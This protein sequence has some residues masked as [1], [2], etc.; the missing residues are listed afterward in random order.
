MNN[1]SGKIFVVTGP[2]G[3]GKD[4]VLKTAKQM[5]L[6][7]GAVITTTTRA[8]RPGEAEENP[9]YFLSREEFE[10]R[11]KNGEMIEYAEVYGNLY[12]NTKEEL[13]KVAKKNE[14]VIIKVDPQGARTY[15][16][17]FPEITTIFIQPPDF[18]FLEKHLVDRATDSPEVIKKRLEVAKEELENLGQWDKIIV[19]YENQL[20]KTAQKLL[21]IIQKQ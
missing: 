18:D 19:N 17:V 1:F 10:T 11:I 12:G 8:M 4:S 16:Q 15:K 3:A 6:K 13:E 21:D 5:G 9:Y 20:E 14:V 7:F 2:S